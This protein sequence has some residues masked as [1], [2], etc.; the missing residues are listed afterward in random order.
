[1]CA[2]AG[3]WLLAVE[4]F[5]IAAM[6]GCGTPSA[7]SRDN[8]GT[9]T[10][11]F[12]SGACAIFASTT[13]SSKPTLTSLTTS[14]LVIAADADLAFAIPGTLTAIKQNKATTHIAAEPRIFAQRI[15]ILFSP[16]PNDCGFSHNPTPSP[17]GGGAGYINI[18]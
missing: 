9:S 5:N 12:T 15:S 1:V 16:Y 8:A 17:Q 2:G 6:T 7:F 4:R 10:A 11:K 13:L 3:A 14:L 18:E